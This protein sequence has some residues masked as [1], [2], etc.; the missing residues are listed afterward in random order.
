MSET[1]FFLQPQYALQI[2]DQVVRM[3]ARLPDWFVQLQRPGAT[4]ELTVRDFS[5]DAFKRLVSDAID[6]TGEPSFGL[7]VGERLR[8]GSHGTLGYAM[9]NSVTPRQ[10]LELVERFVQ[11]RTSLVSAKLETAGEHVR[12]AF[13]ERHPLGDIR[14]PVMEAIVL[15][16]KN[17][18]DYI[19]RGASP[20]AFVALPFDLPGY[21]NLARELFGCDVRYGVEWAGLD[22]Q[23][24]DLDR[25]LGSS[26]ARALTEAVRLCQVELANLS[27]QHALASRVR[28]LM[29]ERVGAFPSQQATAQLLNM[30]PRTLHR[31]LA[32]DGTSYRE[33]LESVRHALAVESVKSGKLS[34]QEIAFLLGYD[35]LGNFRRAFIRWE[36]MSPSEFRRAEPRS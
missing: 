36:G 12:L 13:V 29:L 16:I 1:D 2:S 33:I 7:L 15:T 19:T 20:V 26:N 31:R 32:D 22:F 23:G 21:A 5:F 11:V 18:L 27:R 35:S 6:A 25:P 17:L 14:Q 30:T 4:G 24:G 9:A 8:I 34:L 10:A 28:R 3:G